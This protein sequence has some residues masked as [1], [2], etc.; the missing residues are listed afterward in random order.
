MAWTVMEWLEAGGYMVAIVGGVAGAAVF[1]A[2]KLK[3]FAPFV[4]PLQGEEGTNILHSEVSRV[5]IGKL[6]GMSAIVPEGAELLVKLATETTHS[7]HEGPDGLPQGSGL[8]S[9]GAWFY[10]TTPAPLN[11][12]GREYQRGS[13]GL[14]PT[15]NFVA[16]SGPA[17]LAIHFEWLGEVTISVYERGESSPTW[18]KNIQVVPAVQ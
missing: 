1:I 12:R 16:R 6:V 11:W 5:E 4:Y 15:Q 14:G 7:E 10:R 13:A 9:M 3:R 2:Q 8:A 17:E 18:T